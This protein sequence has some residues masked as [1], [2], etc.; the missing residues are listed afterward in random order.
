[1]VYNYPINSMLH[2][3]SAVFLEAHFIQF[4]YNT[5]LYC[6]AIWMRVWSMRNGRSS[7]NTKIRFD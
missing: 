3:I 7:V 6:P 2:P 1:M 5:Y 4:M